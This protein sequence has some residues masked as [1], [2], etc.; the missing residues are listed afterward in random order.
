[1]IIHLK[2]FAATVSLVALSTAAHAESKPHLLGH[3]CLSFN[4]LGGLVTTDPQTSHGLAVMTNMNEEGGELIL[5]DL[6]THKGERVDTPS[7]QGGWA[8]IELPGNRL[9]YGTF[10]DGHIMVYDLKTRQWIKD[11]DVK[12]EKYF[13]NFA[14]GADGKLYGGTFD[15]GKLISMDPNTYEIKDHGN[16]APPNLYCQRVSNLP[17]GRLLLSYRSE[18]PAVMV[19]DP[20]KETY[21]SAPAALQTVTEGVCWK[22][23]F[24]S[25]V[26][27]FDG[28]TLEPVDWPFYVDYDGKRTSASMAVPL[29]TSGTI[30]LTAGKKL[31]RQREADAEPTLITDS[32]LLGTRNIGVTADGTLVGVRGQQFFT[33][34]A[35]KPAQLV[36]MPVS[37]KPR[38]TLY[39]SLDEDG[40]LW[41]GPEFGQNIFIMN[42]TNGDTTNTQIVTHRGGEVYDAA[43]KDG[44]G[45]MVS[46]VGG[47]IIKYDP[48][49]PWNQVGGKNPRPVASVESAGYIRPAAGCTF[50]PDGKL[51]S[52]WWSAY[53]S[54]G[55]VIAITNVETGEQ[56]LIK[57]PL[58]KQAVCGLDVDD[59]YAY[60]A[61]GVNGNGMPPQKGV[62]PKFGMV[63]LATGKVVF[64]TKFKKFNADDQ[65]TQS[66]PLI[67]EQ[68]THRVVFSRDGNPPQIF[69]PA[70]KALV[71]E[72]KTA[73]APPVHSRVLA[74]LNNGTVL[75]GSHND[76]VEINTT[77]GNTR[78][79]AHF[80]EPVATVA[81][82]PS[83]QVYVG[84][85]TGV[86]EL[87]LTT[88][89]RD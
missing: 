2:Q 86:Y 79:V 58:G 37:P 39:L 14:L 27:A 73:A 81:A 45:Y 4:M 12:G 77:T 52:G 21:T 35:G 87:L 56:R 6:E 11:I 67:L 60:V 40:K 23:L 42:P 57:D 41:G 55:G 24:V 10:Y 31:Y 43:F 78:T 18:M 83:G 1:M 29:S 3:P 26:K 88:E 13:W 30:Y 76:L 72:D 50:G 65:T 82:D 70:T 75:Y 20:A 80:E 63:E 25:A 8:L 53:G 66:A 54:Y 16:G 47:Q 64:E 38:P 59:K 19:F 22:N 69:D 15:G 51:Y 84:A 28:N 61:T 48:R 74:T 71:L 68:K 9:A 33:A 44:V 89:D 7:G 62:A 85:G 34:P 32:T 36:S 46:Y 17:D 49:Q 5:V